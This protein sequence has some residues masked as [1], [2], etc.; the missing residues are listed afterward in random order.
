MI[1]SSIPVYFIFIAWKNKP[2]FFQ[3]GVGKYKLNKFIGEKN[4]I[5][6]KIRNRSNILWN[7]VFQDRAKNQIFLYAHNCFYIAP[8]IDLFYA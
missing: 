3:K 7:F 4:S 6:N 2:K 5:T 1:L 8:M